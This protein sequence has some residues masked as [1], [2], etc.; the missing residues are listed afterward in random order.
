M[1][2]KSLQYINALLTSA[3]CSLGKMWMLSFAFSLIIVQGQAQKQS[4]SGI[5]VSAEDQQPII[6]AT[7]LEK[8]T[9]NGTLTDTEGGFKL[10][11]T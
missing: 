10:E 3:C 1:G 9:Q 4:V 6:G 5:V 11:V 8:G 7:V 2:L